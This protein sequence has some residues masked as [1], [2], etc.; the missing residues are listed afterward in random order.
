MKFYDIYNKNSEASFKEVVLQKESFSLSSVFMPKDLKK[1]SASLIYRDPP[2]SFRDLAFDIIKQFCSEDINDNDLMSI[3]AQF[4]PHRIPVNP[5]APTTY[6]MELFHGDT[7]NYK[8]VGAGFFAQLLEHF[9]KEENQALSMI[10]AASGE[11]ASAL[12]SAFSKVKSVRAFILYPKDSLSEIQSSIISSSGKNVSCFAVDGSL[13]DCNSLVNK[14]LSDKETRQK[15]NLIPGG[16]LNIAPILPQIAFF[17]YGVL[18]VVDRC[19]YDNKIERPAVIISVPSGSFSSLTAAL[20]AKKMGAPIKGFISAENENRVISDWLSSDSKKT[21]EEKDYSILYE[22]FKNLPIHTNTPA[23]D[24]A[25]P[26]NFIRML[27]IYP[28]EELQKLIVPYW[29]DDEATVSAVRDCH[30]RTGCIIDPY[31]AMACT[32][33]HDIYSGALNEL[34]HK[35]EA[36]SGVSKKYADI[37]TWFN[38]LEKRNLVALIAQTS[39][40]GKF[41][42]IMKPAIGRPPSVPDKLERLSYNLKKETVIST[43][44]DELKELLLES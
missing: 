2:P 32:A 38:T 13:R 35:H 22:R 39:H 34:K 12:A 42:E 17:V 4:F 23:L 8:D 28:F 27:K 16:S 1:I 10:I 36:D 29:L 44:Y 37:E 5:I 3:I 19:A 40:P 7:C 9:N 11:R 33:W 31:T 21:F 20:F 24:F 25:S 18:S 14:I 6:I 43:S 41:P 30:D 15:L 26:I